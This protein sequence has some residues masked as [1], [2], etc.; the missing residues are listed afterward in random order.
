MLVQF[1]IMPVELYFIVDQPRYEPA[2]KVNVNMTYVR[3]HSDLFSIIRQIP[4]STHVLIDRF[5]NDI[6]SAFG[7]A[8]SIEYVFEIVRTFS[9]CLYRL[10]LYTLTFSIF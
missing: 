2:R 4:T 8:Q 9:R 1:E 5:L 3:R 7:I 6:L 10:P